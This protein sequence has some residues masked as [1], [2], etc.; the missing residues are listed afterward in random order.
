MPLRVGPRGGLHA[1]SGAAAGD[2][3]D[4]DFVLRDFL[5]DGLGPND[6]DDDHDGQDDDVYCEI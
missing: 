6:D 3:D 1:A 2:D 4:D 5:S